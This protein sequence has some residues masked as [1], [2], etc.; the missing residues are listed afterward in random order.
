VLFR[1]AFQD[2]I[3]RRKGGFSLCR[4]CVVH[5]VLLSL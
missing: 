1:K 3:H 4:P 5:T 2:G